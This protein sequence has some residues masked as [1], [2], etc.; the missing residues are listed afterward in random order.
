VGDNHVPMIKHLFA[1]EHSH[2]TNHERIRILGYRRNAE[3]KRCDHTDMKKSR[4]EINPHIHS[5]VT[6][7]TTPS[8]FP[9]RSMR[10]S[11]ID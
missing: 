9:K 11:H 10:F 1:I 8:I 7:P 6:F 5:L 3:Q 4:A 2:V